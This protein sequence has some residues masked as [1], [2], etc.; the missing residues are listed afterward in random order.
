MALGTIDIYNGAYTGTREFDIFYSPGFFRDSGH[1]KRVMQSQIGAQASQVLEK[2]YQARLLGIGRLG[3]WVLSTK[4]K[5]SSLE[6]IKGMKLRAPQIEGMVEALKFL[7]ANPTPI[8]F[9]EIYLALQNGTVDGFVSALNP[10]VAGKFYEVSKYVLSNPFGE[11]LDKEAISTRAWRRLNEQQQRIM[12]QTFE[13]MEA[14]DYFQ[15]GVNAIT[16]DLATWRRFNGD[17]SVVTID[18]ADITRRMAPLN[19][20][21]ADEVYGAG[22]WDRI[23]SL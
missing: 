13:E 7:G 23:Q 8:A 5:I 21:L 6:E 22:A 9:N 10:S 15:A 4:K 14:T 2:R 18:Q 3:P 17:D 1:S 12:L 11:G 20:R 16:T 19:K